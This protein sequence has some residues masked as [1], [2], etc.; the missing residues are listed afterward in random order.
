MTAK[1]LII[2]EIE[3]IPDFLVDEVLDF[4]QFIKA[5][6]QQEKLETTILSESSLQNDWLRPEED[7]AWQDL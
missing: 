1:D 5:K 2:Q 3:N 4:L 6:Y 7:A